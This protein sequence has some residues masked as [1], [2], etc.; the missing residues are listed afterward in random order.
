M[1]EKNQI[2]KP[3]LIIKKLTFNDGTTVRLGNSSILV[4]TGANNCGKSQVLKDIERITESGNSLKTIVLS[5]CEIEY[6]GTIDEKT[7]L[8]GSFLLTKEEIINYTFREA[9]FHWIA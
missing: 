5:D 3:R 9:L 6:I 1:D 2:E 7:F 4:F 8:E